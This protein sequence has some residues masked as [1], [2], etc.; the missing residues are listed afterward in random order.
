MVMSLQHFFHDLH[1]FDKRKTAFSYASRM[2]RLCF[3]ARAKYKCAVLLGGIVLSAVPA[4]AESYTQ[5]R[6]AEQGSLNGGAR[7]ET[8]HWGYS[9][10]GYVGGLTDQHKGSAR[11]DVVMDAPNSGDY[12]LAVRYANATGSTQSLSLWIDEQFERQLRFPPASHWGD[13]Q[14]QQIAVAVTAGT[15]LVSLRFEE[16]DSGNVN[17]DSLVLSQRENSGLNVELEGA[18]LSGGTRVENNHPGYGGDGFVGG[19][20]DA[21]RPYAAVSFDV[22]PSVAGNYRLDIRYANGTGSQ[23]TLTLWNNDQ[24]LGD[25][26]F[27]PTAGWAAWGSASTEVELESG[28]TNL[29]LQFAENNNGNVNL[30]AASLELI[31]SQTPT[32][33]P[34]PT[35][36]PTP[37]QT[38]TATPTPTPPPEAY[39]TFEA[40]AGFIDGAAYMRESNGRSV[41]VQ[42]AQ[43]SSRMVFIVNA[44]RSGSQTLK[45]RYRL[46]SAQA[47][48]LQLRVDGIHTQDILLPPAGDWQDFSLPVVLEEGVGSVGLYSFGQLQGDVEWDFAQ[49]QHGAALAARGASRSEITYEAEAA[50]TNGMKQ[51]PSREYYTVMA[52]AS[53]RQFVRL[54]SNQFIEFQLTED[55]NAFVLRFSIADSQDGQ[56]RQQS[57]AM[58]VDGQKVR[59]VELDSTYAWVYGGY[60]FSNNPGDGLAHRFFD[61]TQV[62]L[63]QSVAAGSVIRFEQQ[64]GNAQFV[65]IDFLEAER[66]SPRPRPANALS[67]TD[68]GAQANDHQSDVSALR[69]AL[70]A[71][72]AQGKVVWIPQ[73]RFI[74]D[75]LV[76]INNA[77]VVG[78]GPWYSIL[79]GRN[80]LGGFYADGSNVTLAHFMFDGDVRYREPDN[81]PL[82][83]STN[84]GFEGNFGQNSLIQNVWVEHAKAGLWLKPGTDGLLGLKLRIRDTFADGMNM[85]DG[86]RDTVITQSSFRNTGDDAMA[87]WSY[88]ASNVNNAYINNTA[89]SPALANG[90]AI[91]GGESNRLQGL[92]IED[93][94]AF[95][96]GIAISTHHNPQPFSGTTRVENSTIIRSGGKEHNWNAEF[97]ALWMFAYF[98]EITAEVVIRDVDVIDSTYQGLLMSTDGHRIENVSFDDVVIDG[99]GSQAIQIFTPGNASMK[100]VKIFNAPSQLSVPSNFVISDEG[101][102]NFNVAP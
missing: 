14:T 77:T 55:A 24:A 60:P 5:T 48:T 32:P 58:Y 89:Q 67:I 81:G 84:P 54:L 6:E 65:D 73:G 36:S 56:G 33:S 59:D 70:E 96:A 41:V 26:V 20:T 7:V 62:L 42:P 76:Y 22:A 18:S 71:A 99:T 63:D 72:R 101:G 10:G 21:N 49:L 27:A 87:M 98:K 85:V 9:G 29:R 50:N 95:G 2:T 53:Q 102:N 15:H 8:E 11:V 1:K 83:N 40:E 47:Q 38:P 92:L 39:T 37:T 43:Q 78:A 28:L 3:P 17:I 46:P 44:E 94:V 31:Q 34:S 93:T 88:A 45:L 68:F 82:V 23:R 64:S 80:H 25:I 86:V 35:L 90:A 30:D 4:F 19:F 13:Y 79:A 91:Y 57:L 97:G 74:V 66:V 16:Q 75:E 12:E 61:E 51:G 100:D 69:Q 52:E